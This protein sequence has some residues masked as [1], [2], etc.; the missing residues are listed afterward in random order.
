MW[1]AS[2]VSYFLAQFRKEFSDNV[3]SGKPFAV[4]ASKNFSRITPLVSMKKY[5]GRAM[6]LYWPMASA[7]QNLIGANNFGVGI[8]KQG[9]IDFAAIREIFQY[10]FAIVADA[11]NFQALFFE[12]RLSV[13]QLDQLPFAI[14]SPICRTKK[15]Q[16]R[17]VRSFQAIQSLLM[18]KLVAQRKSGSLL[19]DRQPDRGE[20][21]QGRDM[22]CIAL[23]RASDRDAVSQMPN[24]FVLGIEIIDL[25][26]R[27][28]V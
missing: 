19:A 2:T 24:S 1:G 28:V 11:R 5:P 7:V 20:Q 23:E 10:G 21:L 3:V 22:D 4:L 18:S 6:P 26:G 9:E 25:P 17:A 15:E 27:I 14:G 13:L 12:S 8:G 16:D